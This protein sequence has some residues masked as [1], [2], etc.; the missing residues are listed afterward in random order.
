MSERVSAAGMA[1]APAQGSCFPCGTCFL[2]AHARVCWE[3]GAFPSSLISGPDLFCLSQ[4]WGCGR[5][6]EFTLLTRLEH[7]GD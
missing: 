6:L 4:S 2:R 5:L 1:D 3:L 7:S